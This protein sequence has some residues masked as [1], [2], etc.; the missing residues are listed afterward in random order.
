MGTTE[1]KV[2]VAVVQKMARVTVTAN[3][4]TIQE[5]KIIINRRKKNLK[6]VQGLILILVVEM[7][8]QDKAK[9]R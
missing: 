6:L 1:A 8:M 7:V 4:N 2:N 5:T 3:L 9:I